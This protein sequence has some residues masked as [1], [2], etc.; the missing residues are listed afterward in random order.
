MG[1]KKGHRL[2]SRANSVSK[3][4]Q[5]QPLSFLISRAKIVLG[6]LIF[7]VKRIF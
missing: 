2:T 3:I 1:E 7:R 5:I 4:K 6:R